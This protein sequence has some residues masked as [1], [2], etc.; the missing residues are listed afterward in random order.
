MKRGNWVRILPTEWSIA[1]GWCG[2]MGIVKDI[3]RVLEDG[4]NVVSVKIP[5]GEHT[6]CAYVSTV[7]VCH[8]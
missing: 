8:S 6:V 7:M 2:R 4:V 5:I 1:N 3:F